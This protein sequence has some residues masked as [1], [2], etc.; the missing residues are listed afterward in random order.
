[1]PRLEKQYDVHYY[2]KSHGRS[3]FNITEHAVDNEK[4]AMKLA[5]D[6]MNIRKRNIQAVEVYYLVC[7]LDDSYQKSE[8]TPP[9]DEEG[10]KKIKYGD[11]FRWERC[12]N[13]ITF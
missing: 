1:M 4:E 2:S 6:T 13:L 7:N 10:W 5:M 9:T 11:D 3:H 8:T 12:V